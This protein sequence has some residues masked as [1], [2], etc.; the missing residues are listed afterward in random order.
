MG[1]K[2]EFGSTIRLAEFDVLY[3][4]VYGKLR[5]KEVAGR[6]FT[7]EQSTVKHLYNARK[8]L[9]VPNTTQLALLFQRLYPTED[10]ARKGRHWIAA[11]QTDRLS[12]ALRQ[13][14][15]T[16]SLAREKKNGNKTS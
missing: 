12:T 14:Q 11:A 5:V 4:I 7:T 1:M 6:R 3:A 13:A 10:K 16:R 9:G 8:R 2:P 15:S